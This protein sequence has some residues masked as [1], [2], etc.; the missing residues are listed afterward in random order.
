MFSQPPIGS[1]EFIFYI[2]WKKKEEKKE[3]KGRKKEKKNERKR[4]RKNREKKVKK[5]YRKILVVNKCQ[6]VWNDGSFWFV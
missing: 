4:K 6:V 2:I 1:V 3:K 5:L